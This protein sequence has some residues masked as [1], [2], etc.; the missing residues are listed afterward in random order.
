MIHQQKAGV[1]CDIRDGSCNASLLAIFSS[2]KNERGDRLSPKEIY[3]QVFTFL[4]SGHETISLTG[5]WTLYL[6]SKYPEW[7]SDL[8]Q[9]IKRAVGDGEISWKDLDKLTILDNCIKESLRLYPI[10]LTT[11]RTAIGPDRLGPYRIPGGTNVMIGNG[12]LHRD[13]KFW[14]DP[15][16]FRPSRFDLKCMYCLH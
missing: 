1:G 16:V 4:V 2:M 8:R 11:D 7:Q 3:H 5:T 9:E 13:E 10:A 14:K 15:D 6:L 12:T